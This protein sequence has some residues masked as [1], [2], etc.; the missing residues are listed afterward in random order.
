[1]PVGEGPIV[2]RVE[3]TGGV[4]RRSDPDLRRRR[5]GEVEGG[6]DVAA[7]RHVAAATAAAKL[8]ETQ[9]QIGKKPIERKG[10]QNEGMAA[11]TKITPGG[12]SDHMR[13]RIL[14]YEGRSAVRHREREPAHP[15]HPAHM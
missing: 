14:S 15:H 1:M 5:R 8:S 12:V 2:E 4:A 7:D 10:R 9:L 3:G 6:G 13:L 11:R